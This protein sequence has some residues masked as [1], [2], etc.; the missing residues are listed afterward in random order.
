MGCWQCGF[1]TI[2]LWHALDRA[3]E[4]TVKTYVNVKMDQSVMI[5]FNVNVEHFGNQKTKLALK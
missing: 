1:I 5:G 2:H 4:E 3:A